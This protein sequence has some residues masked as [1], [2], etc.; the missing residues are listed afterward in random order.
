MMYAIKMADQAHEE[1]FLPAWL[2]P[3][4]ASSRTTVV[5]DKGRMDGEALVLDA[6][7]DERT[8]AIIATLRTKRPSLRPY[9]W[10]QS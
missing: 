2:L 4:V 10:G 7:P 6:C 1:D 5:A 3:P 8:Q 9:S